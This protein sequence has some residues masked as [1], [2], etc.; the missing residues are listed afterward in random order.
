MI[1]S[2]ME[3]IVSAYIAL[4]IS[5]LE[6]TNTA[7]IEATL[8]VTGLTIIHVIVTNLILFFSVVIILRGLKYVITISE[9]FN[10]QIMLGFIVGSNVAIVSLLINMIAGFI[11]TPE[12]V[13]FLLYPFGITL[14]VLT[15]AILYGCIG[16]IVFIL[17]AKVFE[18]SGSKT[19]G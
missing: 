19:Q 10:S 4:F 15:N 14:M 11:L 17:M 8:I 2:G 1:L 9:A 6:N 12:S 3:V 16:I 13:I 5:P 7:N 18:L